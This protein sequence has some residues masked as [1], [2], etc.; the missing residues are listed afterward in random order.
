MVFPRAERA[1][2]K[3]ISFRQGHCRSPAASPPPSDLLLTRERSAACLRHHAAPLTRCNSGSPHHVLMG[4][5][6]ADRLATDPS[7]RLGDGAII[8]RVVLALA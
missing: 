4:F 3:L 7:N 1:D 5:V 6:A 2:S 8:N